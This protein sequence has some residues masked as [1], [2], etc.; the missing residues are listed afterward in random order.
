MFPIKIIKSDLTGNDEKCDDEIGDGEM[1]DDRWNPS[2][3]QSWTDQRWKD[4]HVTHGREDEEDG[5]GDDGRQDPRDV[6]HVHVRS[7][8]DVFE[9]VTTVIVTLCHICDK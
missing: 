6:A 9:S 3:S 1:K 8:C 4:G 7:R 2:F 5:H